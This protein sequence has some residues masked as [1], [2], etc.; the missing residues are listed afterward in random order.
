MD[1]SGDDVT[2]SESQYSAN[3]FLVIPSFSLFPPHFNTVI[4]NTDKAVSQMTLV[5]CHVSKNRYFPRLAHL[6]KVLFK[7]KS[8]VDEITSHGET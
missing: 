6:C 5:M 3:R 8:L 2:A 1:I 4:I 7:I